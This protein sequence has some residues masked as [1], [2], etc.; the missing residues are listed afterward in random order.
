MQR[1]WLP[2]FALT[3][4]LLTAGCGWH[5][6]G[7]TEVPP[8]G[9]FYLSASDHHSHLVTSLN[10]YLRDGD[11]E[12]VGDAT[13]ADYSLV[14]LAERADSRTAT[15]NASSRAAELLLTEEADFT[16]LDREGRPVLPRA[17]VVVERSYEYTEINALASDN[18]AELLKR[19]MQA[20]LAQQI[21]RQLR[22][23]APLADA[24]APA[25]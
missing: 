12:V 20:D 21:V 25:S 19:E 13:A 9:R 10:S 14:I 24:K 11:V 18:E 17:T 1:T 8:I 22:R 3:A 15:V 2:L 16:V 5:L 23:L 4:A 7:A 6:R